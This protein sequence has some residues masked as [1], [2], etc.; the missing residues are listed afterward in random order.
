MFLYSVLQ[1]QTLNRSIHTHSINQVRKG[2]YSSGIGK[3]RKFAKQLEPMRKLLLPTMKNMKRNNELPFSTQINWLLDPNYPY[4][5]KV[6]GRN[7]SVK[8]DS[9]DS[10]DVEQLTSDKLPQQ[11]VKHKRNQVDRSSA[12]EAH[13]KIEREWRARYGKEDEQ[14]TVSASETTT[15]N[16]RPIRRGK[17]GKIRKKC[18]VFRSDIEGGIAHE[19]SNR[20]QEKSFKERCPRGK[21]KGKVRRKIFI[22]ESNL[23]K[24]LES[25]KDKDVVYPEFVR[26]LDELK[27]RMKSEHAL[28]IALP[29]VVKALQYPS[30]DEVLDTLTAYGISF[31]NMGNLK[32]A[33][34]LLEPLVDYRKDLYSAFIALAS[35]YA[36]DGNL[37]KAFA[38]IDF[39]TQQLDESQWVSD[40]CERRAQVPRRRMSHSIS[41]P[42]S[43][44]LVLIT[45]LDLML[46]RLLTLLSGGM[47]RCKA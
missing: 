11:K 27:S 47:T 21:A 23:K 14:M 19:E 33:I 15:E 31:F 38:S 18:R 24:D 17:L 44:S 9:S 16:I 1:F 12:S 2:I 45:C 30:G 7:D 29:S 5:E 41:L 46:R 40:V 25:H 6:Y 32:Q 3:W 43:H 13:A 36:L 34:Q 35:A 4:E 8:S 42:F 10:S 39:V 26:I 20:N 22:S 37:P 28:T